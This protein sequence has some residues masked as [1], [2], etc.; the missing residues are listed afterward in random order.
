MAEASASDVRVEIDTGLA[1]SDIT[2]ILARVERDWKR[3]YDSSDFQ[4]TNHI[5]DFEATL[6]AYRIASGRD[7]RTSEESRESASL[8]WD[9]SETEKL[10]QRVMQLDPGDAFGLGNITRDTDRY[11]TSTDMDG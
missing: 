4:D 1:D 8:K 9:A 11:V 2:D 7:R 6:T 3:E 10:R 5:Q